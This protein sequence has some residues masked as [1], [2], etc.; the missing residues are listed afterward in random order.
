MNDELVCEL[1][2]VIVPDEDLA[3]RQVELSRQMADRYPPVIELTSV[4]RRL[5]FAPH[6]TIYQVPI[7][8]TDMAALQQALGALASDATTFTLH[9]TEYGANEEEGSFEVRYEA[10]GELMQFQEELIGVVNP[11]RGSRLIERDPAGRKLSDLVQESGARGDNIRRTGFD[12]VGDPATG[13]LFHPHSTI[14][15]FEFGSR[16]RSRRPASPSRLDFRR[17]LRRAGDL[18][19]RSLWNVCTTTCGVQARRHD[20]VMGITRTR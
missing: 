3:K 17:E 1:N 8:N 9:A 19:A 14:N 13:G 11:I 12:A 18:H 2:R 16:G 4:N 6:L 20:I 7:A 5:G 10:A 15:W